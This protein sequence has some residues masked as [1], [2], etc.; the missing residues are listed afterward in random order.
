MK[1]KQI[2]QMN[3]REHGLRGIGDITYTYTNNGKNHTLEIHLHLIDKVLRYEGEEAKRNYFF[4]IRDGDKDK[5]DLIK[6]IASDAIGIPV[7]RLKEN[8]RKK[9][10]VWARNLIMWYVHKYMGY[11]LSDAGAIFNKDH[12][13]VIHSIK[14][15]D[16]PDKYLAEYQKTSKNTFLSK[17]SSYKLFT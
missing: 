3:D 5:I 9:E 10:V 1:R 15:I 7:I 4:L 14:R 2:I 11:T 17:C 16:T 8:N 6:R 12:S 13:S